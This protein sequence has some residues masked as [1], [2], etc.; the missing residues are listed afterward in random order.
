MAVGGGMGTQ[1]W[2]EWGH[3]RTWGPGGGCKAEHI[4][5]QTPGWLLW[6]VGEKPGARPGSLCDRLRGK[7]SVLAALGRRRR[8]GDVCRLP[9]TASRLKSPWL[10]YAE[11]SSACRRVSE[12]REAAEGLLGLSSPSG[13]SH[14]ACPPAVG[15]AWGLDPSQHPHTL[16]TPGFWSLGQSC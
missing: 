12:E 14:W 1:P 8:Q 5:G 15:L 10:D 4:Q 3:N 7:L 16:Q 2:T 6:E 11:V 13:A 9:P